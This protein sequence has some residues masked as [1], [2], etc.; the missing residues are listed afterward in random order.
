MKL[1]QF[2]QLLQNIKDNSKEDPTIT[3]A[4]GIKIV[5]PVYIKESNTVII[6]DSTE[7]ELKHCP[8]CE[9]GPEY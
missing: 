8:N 6:T 5:P 1:S 2:I 9:C 7:L 3:M 4:D